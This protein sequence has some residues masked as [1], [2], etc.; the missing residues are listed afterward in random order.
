MVQE[1]QYT[2]N[3]GQAIA[4]APRMPAWR[5]GDPFGAARAH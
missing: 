5:K 2:L 4:N 1:A 3:L